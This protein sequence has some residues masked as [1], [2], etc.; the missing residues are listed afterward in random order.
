MDLYAWLNLTA[1]EE[2]SLAK[3]DLL[4]H[5]RN[6]DNSWAEQ[7]NKKKALIREYKPNLQT[8]KNGAAPAIGQSLLGAILG[9]EKGS[10]I[11]GE[12]TTPA[13]SNLDPLV[14]SRP[15]RENTVLKTDGLIDNNPV[16]EQGIQQS[17]TTLQEGTDGQQTP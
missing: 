10:S 6:H 2:D 13:T 5:T 9:R 12:S 11:D 15:Q 4:P 14:S 7:F 17:L 8:I 3:W 16:P 1:E